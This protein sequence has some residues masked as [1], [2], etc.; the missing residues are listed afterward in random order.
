MCL[1]VHE[2]LCR[3]LFRKYRLRIGGVGEGGK[4]IILHVMPM[5][6]K[7]HIESIR[8]HPL[9]PGIKDGELDHKGG[10]RVF[11]I[12]KKRRTNR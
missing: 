8:S 10:C 1:S 7:K 2:V 6:I 12:S 3:S 9:E 4:E 11:S 5:D